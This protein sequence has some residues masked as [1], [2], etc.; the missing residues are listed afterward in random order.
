MNNEP[1]ERHL[2]GALA[3]MISKGVDSVESRFY[4]HAVDTIFRDPETRR[5]YATNEKYVTPI[6]FCPFC[7]MELQQPE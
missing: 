7:G 1:M 3:Q 6:R 5:W 4:G 2:C